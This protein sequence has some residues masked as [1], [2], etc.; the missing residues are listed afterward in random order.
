MTARLTRTERA[1]AE[2]ALGV[3]RR[4][5]VESAP[6]DEHGRERT[7]GA[8]EAAVRV[9]VVRDARDVLMVARGSARWIAWDARAACEAGHAAD[10]VRARLALYL[11]ALLRADRGDFGRGGMV[12]YACGSLRDNTHCACCATRRG[13]RVCSCWG[14]WRWVDVLPI[15]PLWQIASETREGE[16][17]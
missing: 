14:K 8:R 11:R 9:A 10:S 13:E 4:S 17:G 6:R 12:C 15:R 5:C 1:A 16:H 2:L 3:L 7:F